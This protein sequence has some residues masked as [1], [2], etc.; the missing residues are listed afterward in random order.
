VT[1]NNWIFYYK[2]W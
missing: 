2:L 1:R